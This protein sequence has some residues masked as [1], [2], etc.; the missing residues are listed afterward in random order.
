MRLYIAAS[1]ANRPKGSVEAGDKHWQIYANDQAKKAVDYIPLIVS[2]R[3]GAA[4]RL[5]DLG[6]VVDSVQ[7]VRNA[8]LFN[9][10]PSVL[11]IISKQP[12]ANVIETVDRVKDIIAAVAGFN[13][14]GDQFTDWFGSYPN[15]PGIIERG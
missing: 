10:K 2:Y 4:V 14:G 11:L 9:G 1:N 5:S 7:D 8:G 15:N 12:G 6:D 3:N 13:T